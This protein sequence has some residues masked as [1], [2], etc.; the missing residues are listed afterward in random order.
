MPYEEFWSPP[1][2]ALV[3]HDVVVYHT[4]RHDNVNDLISDYWY[5][6]D[7]GSDEGSG[8]QFD[9][10]DFDDVDGLSATCSMDHPAILRHLIDDPDWLAEWRPSDVDDPPYRSDCPKCQTDNPG[11][12]VVAC[13]F[14]TGPDFTVFGAHLTP[15]DIPA[16][17]RVQCHHCQAIF[18][19][20]ELKQPESHG[21]NAEGG[22]S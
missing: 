11:F 13:T 3:H 15:D 5:T 2:V 19:S 22:S 17:V 16:T 7:P 14:G 12:S 18:D 21:E 9:I 1:P 20:D 6:L 4:Y 10:R 8:T